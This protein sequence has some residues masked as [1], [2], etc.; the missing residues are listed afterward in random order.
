MKLTINQKDLTKALTAASRV[1]SARATIPILTMVRFESSSPNKVSL[2]A[3]DLDIEIAINTEAKVEQGGEI[4]VP[5][6]AFRDIANKLNAGADVSL[7]AED[8]R[9][10]IKSGRSKFHINTLPT[11]DWPEIAD[12]ETP[13]RFDMPAAHIGQ[14]IEKTSFAVSTEETR[15]YLNGIYLHV[16][17]EGPEATLRGVAT[18]G[19]RLSRYDVP[20]PAQATASLPGVIVPRKT[21]AEVDRILKDAPE[22]ITIRMAQNFIRFEIGSVT[23]ASK[24]I[25]GSF[26]DYA[27]VIP[28]NNDKQV[29]LDAQTLSASVA[30]VST[31]SSERGRAV[32]MSFGDLRLINSVQNPDMG[33]AS[34]EIDC[35]WRHSGTFEI[36]FNSKYIVEC[37]D[38]LGSGMVTMH[39]SDPGAPCL[40]CNESDGNLLIVLMPMRV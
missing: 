14:I 8:G 23:L 2:R 33:D 34:D 36:G 5:A 38:V 12:K 37:M 10:T 28:Q 19:H 22:T 15:Y 25:D 1:A 16:A 3:T 13:H 26:P 21:V 32:K 7:S 39:F 30:R 17:G 29:S 18:D 20:L 31:V 35:E 24:I 11:S 4:C 6:A 9:L 27:R 40:M